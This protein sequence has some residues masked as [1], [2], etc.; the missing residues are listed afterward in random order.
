MDSSLIIKSKLDNINQVEKIID[1]ISENHDIPSDLY[2]KILIATIEAVNNAIVHGNK[3]DPN[4]NVHIQF[5]IDNKVL[6]ISIQ[7]EG[8]GFNFKEIPDPTMP[9]N[10]ENISG[11]GVFLMNKL[12][13]KMIFNENGT[14]V[15]LIFNI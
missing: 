6:T 13:D 4:K 3:L 1:D 7:D 9:E 5:N 14:K 8:K 11:R 15:E 12:T 2:G 10:I